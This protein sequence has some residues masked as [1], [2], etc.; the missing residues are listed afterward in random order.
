ML[1]RLQVSTCS[2]LRSRGLTTIPSSGRCVRW[3]SHAATSGSSQGIRTLALPCC[4]YRRGALLR[5]QPSPIPHATGRGLLGAFGPKPTILVEDCSW[6]S[7]PSSAISCSSRP[8]SLRVPS[9]LTTADDCA[10]DTP[11]QAPL[12]EGPRFR[13][14]R[15]RALV[16]GRRKTCQ[17]HRPRREVPGSG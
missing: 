4:T 14:T 9:T 5:A 12:P 16:A 3:P 1:V 13:I 15:L 6:S 2:A 10:C 7:P 17:W 11:C 8:P